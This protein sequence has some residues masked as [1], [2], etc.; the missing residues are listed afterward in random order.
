M[1]YMIDLSGH[2]GLFI[3]KVFYNRCIY[4]IKNCMLP[5]HDEYLRMPFLDMLI[6]LPQLNPDHTLEED[7][8]DNDLN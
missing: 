6:M 4:R 7:L 2:L 3:F 1:K 8:L 5:L